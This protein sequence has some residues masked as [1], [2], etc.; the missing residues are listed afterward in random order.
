VSAGLIGNPDLLH[1]YSD[2]PDIVAGSATPGTDGALGLINPT[3]RTIAATVDGY[4]NNA[5]APEQ[6]KTA[7]LVPDP[8]ATDAVM[9]VARGDNGC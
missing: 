1:T 3:M 9:G 8:T 6:E 5:S 2:A 7:S 4:R